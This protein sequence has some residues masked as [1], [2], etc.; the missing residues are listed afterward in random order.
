MAEFFSSL[1]QIRQGQPVAP[2]VVERARQHCRGG[3]VVRNLGELYEWMCAQNPETP[4]FDNRIAA[5]QYPTALAAFVTSSRWDAWKKH[6]VYALHGEVYLRRLQSAKTMMPPESFR[7]HVAGASMHKANGYAHMARAAAAQGL[8]ELTL[9][10]WDAPRALGEISAQA[11]A[12]LCVTCTL[13]SEK[14]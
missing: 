11:V 10:T 13:R 7:D 5:G 8:A 9:P 2:D 4:Y 6:A 14:Y 3:H 12:D 1:T